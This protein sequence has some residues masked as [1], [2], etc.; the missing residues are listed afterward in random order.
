[1]KSGKLVGGSKTTIQDHYLFTLKM[2]NLVDVWKPWWDKYG[3]PTF[4]ASEKG[5]NT[6][7]WADIG[8]TGKD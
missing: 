3:Y 1:M 7:K 8:I 6:Y 5:L 4:P 2:K